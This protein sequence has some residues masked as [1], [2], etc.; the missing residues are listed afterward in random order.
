MRNTRLSKILF[1]TASLTVLIFGYQSVS[2]QN[3]DPS[4]PPHI[5]VN[6]SSTVSIA[7][8]RAEIDV[9]VV[10]QA[11]NSQ[12]AVSQNAT[13][14]EA[15]LSQLRQLLG[16]NADIK[17]ISYSVTPQYRYPKE[18]GEPT[19]IGYTATNIVRVTLD[20]LTKVGTVIDT[21]VKGGTNR[22]QNLRFTVKDESAAQAQALQKAAAQAALKSKAMAAAIN[23]SARRVISLVENSS[24][25]FP[26]REMAFAR[27]D[28]ALTPIEPGTIDVEASVTLTVEITQ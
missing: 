10:T 2:A 7:P 16:Q 27:A 15:A 5:R 8:D 6:G 21:A 18:G 14:L 20:D 11:D 4:L 25:S 24:P 12:A 13:K 19:I 23:M 3:T 22:I 1:S 28:A 9:G 26:V 17:T